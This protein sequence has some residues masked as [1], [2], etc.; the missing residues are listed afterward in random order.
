MRFLVGFKNAHYERFIPSFGNL[1]RSVADH[2]VGALE[3]LPDET[4]FGVAGPA[5]VGVGDAYQ[6]IPCRMRVVSFVV[7]GDGREFRYIL[8]R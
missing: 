7:D 4:G 2:Y 1:Y 6:R 5:Q 8:R 3:S